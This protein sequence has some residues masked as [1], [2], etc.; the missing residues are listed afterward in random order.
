MLEARL[1]EGPGDLP[2]VS[3]GDRHG[4]EPNAIV[5]LSHGTS[6]VE[7][8]HEI[9]HD[10]RSHVVFMP[11]YHEPLKLRIL[12]TMVD[13]VR[14]YPDS[15][16]GRRSWADRV[17]YRE[18]DGR[19]VPVCHHWTNGEPMLIRTFIMAMRL[20]EFRG[21][22]SALRLALNDRAIW[23]DQGAVI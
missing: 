12:Q 17:Y 13:I 1:E 15:L 23:S 9:R 16:E 4:L 7:F 2:V 8:I 6:L 22:R 19:A 20:A 5:N 10:R 18:A 11:Q 14:D 21:I 3:G